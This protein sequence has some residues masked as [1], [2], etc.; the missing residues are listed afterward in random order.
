MNYRIKWVWTRFQQKIYS[1]RWVAFRHW[2]DENES[3]FAR[4]K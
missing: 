4:A 1:I 3:Y 2:I